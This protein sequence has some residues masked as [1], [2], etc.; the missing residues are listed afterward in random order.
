MS[1][2]FSYFFTCQRKS[3]VGLHDFISRPPI[4]IRRRRKGK[5]KRISLPLPLLMSV[6]LPSLSLTLSLFALS[7]TPFSASPLWLQHPHKPH[8]LPLGF[9][10]WNKQRGSSVLRLVLA[11]AGSVRSNTG[12]EGVDFGCAEVCAN[13]RSFSRLSLGA[14]GHGYALICFYFIYACY[15]LSG[16]RS[17]V[18][19]PR[20]CVHKKH[21]SLPKGR[22]L[23]VRCSC[24]HDGGGGVGWAGWYSK[25]STKARGGHFWLLWVWVKAGQVQNDFQSKTTFF[26]FFWWG[27]L[28]D[29]LW[30]SI[31]VV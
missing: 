21:P 3:S 17:D 12:A 7:R 9:P 29:L 13:S 23:Y 8:S 1:S 5:R 28:D 19:V 22:T 30:S 26:F 25:E 16:R 15:L 27:W 2:D 10:F 20:K 11:K 6:P 14:C 24:W 18:A 31:A 4:P